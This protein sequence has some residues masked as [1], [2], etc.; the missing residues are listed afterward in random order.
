LFNSI[1]SK[2]SADLILVVIVPFFCYAT[3]FGTTGNDFFT[4]IITQLIMGSILYKDG[5][6]LTSLKFEESDNK[7]I[8]ATVIKRIQI[9]SK[10]FWTWKWCI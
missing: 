2:C 10:Y 3:P 5:T 4:F 1:S 9:A 8:L 7:K 6:I